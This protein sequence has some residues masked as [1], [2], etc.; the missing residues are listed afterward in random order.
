MK[1]FGYVMCRNI[2]FAILNVLFYLENTLKFVSR[3][4][5]T[6]TL[7]TNLGVGTH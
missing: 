6:W 2:K 1:P 7:A 3:T 5:W 4:V